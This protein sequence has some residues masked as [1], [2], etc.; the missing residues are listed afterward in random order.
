M[1]PA[2]VRSGMARITSALPLMSPSVTARPVA[3]SFDLLRPRRSPG[4]PGLLLRRRSGSR[5]RIGGPHVSR[6]EADHADRAGAR[7]RAGH[8]P[9]QVSRLGLIENQ[10]VDVGRGAVRGS[11]GPARRTEWS[12]SPGGVEHRLR[13]PRD[14][15]SR[16]RSTPSSEAFCTAAVRS[17]I[18]AGVTSVG[19]APSRPAA[20][21]IP[22]QASS[23]GVPSPDSPMAEI[24]TT[25]ATAFV[26]GLELA[27]PASASAVGP[28]VG[29]V[30]GHGGCRRRW[31]GEEAAGRNQG[32]GRDDA[33]RDGDAG[34]G[35]GRTAQLE[36]PSVWCVGSIVRKRG[37]FRGSGRQLRREAT[38]RSRAGWFRAGDRPAG[39]VGGATRGG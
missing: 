38:S 16:R 5:W 39:R 15:R 9:R 36:A 34:P 4:R 22:C 11:S 35:S 13:P 20:S 27:G 1:T 33:A 31:V 7:D 30:A 32:R 28:R 2:P 14:R 12:C 18:E 25:D 26:G 6:R 21:W 19:V 17:A 37:S 10:P 3:G 24:R 23:L 29:V 8:E